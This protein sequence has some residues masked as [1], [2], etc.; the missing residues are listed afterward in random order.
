MSPR[1][2]ASMPCTAAEAPCTVVM[3]GMFIDTAADRIS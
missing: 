3:H 2:P 1:I